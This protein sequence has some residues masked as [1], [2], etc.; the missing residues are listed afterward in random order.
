M[1]TVAACIVA[2]L[3]SPLL[4][5]AGL[6]T[7][8]VVQCWNKG[9]DAISISCNITHTSDGGAN[10][11]CIVSTYLGGRQGARTDWLLEGHVQPISGSHPIDKKEEGL[12]Y[13]YAPGAFGC[14]ISPPPG[15]TYTVGDCTMNGAVKTCVVGT[16]VDGSNRY[17]H[18]TTS[19]RPYRQ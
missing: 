14:A 11:H 19:A 17:F 4:A 8:S 10:G 13:S 12:S 16:E 7:D 6:S 3:S 9:E 15:Y 2:L 18:A 5:H 1:K